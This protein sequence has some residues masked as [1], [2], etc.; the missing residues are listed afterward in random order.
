MLPF[1]SLGATK[2]DEYFAAGIHSEL[3][4]QLAQVSGLRVIA[5]TSVLSYRNTARGAREIAKELG[6]GA[7]L[8]GSV[9]R[10]GNRVR[11]TANLIDA[12]TERDLWAERYD[13][14]LA[15]LFAIQ[16]E[17]AQDIAGK[18]GA[19]LTSDE[20]A[21]LSRPPT[22]SPE[23]YDHYLRGLDYWQRSIWDVDGLRLA[24]VAFEKAA[25]AD[26]SFALAHARLGIA[27]TELSFMEV[28]SEPTLKAKT[29]VEID[30]ALALQPDLPEARFALGHY[31][32]HL[33]DFGTALREYENALRGA[34]GNAEFISNTGSV[35]R[36]QGR[37]DEALARFASAAS[38]DPR[39]REP[40]E[41]LADT[42]SKLRRYS[43]A[44][45]ACGRLT[46]LAPELE[47]VLAL[48]AFLPS[49]QDGDIA[50]AGVF[51]SQLRQTSFYSFGP[52]GIFFERVLG[53]HPK[54][55]LEVLEAPHFEEI[56][57]RAPFRPRALLRAR[58][59]VALG[60]S[61]RARQEFVAA[62]QL[63]LAEV[64]RNPEDPHRLSA[65]AES[66]AG[67]GEHEESL[68]MARRAVA[69]RP[70]ESDAYEGPQLLE[71]FAAVA[72]ATGNTDDALAALE[73][74]L[75]VPSDLSEALLRVDPRWAPLRG[76]A[77]FEAL[78]TLKVH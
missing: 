4:A 13:R 53:L 23:A 76:N 59:Y 41:H 8:E 60:E 54:R 39:F 58:A 55:A 52:P 72:A 69:M 62:R 40:Q 44:Q 38:L 27:W 47:A 5:R 63:S 25:S 50:P 17:I 2:D 78:I 33:R 51:L 36:R 22:R 10:A 21:R 56:A 43:E 20:R 18:L 35:A 70:M 9:Q 26:P 66:L 7:I 31:F 65:L 24:A 75:V 57:L 32:Y 37:W 74:L 11:V 34:P 68:R 16:T 1:D 14:D 15:D 64:A 48:C 19:R 29:K 49:K 12:R 77:R 6:V 42:L 3:I 73:R 30:R 45:R 46:A 71:D 28:D 61:E 67:L